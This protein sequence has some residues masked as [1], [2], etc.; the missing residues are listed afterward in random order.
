M[1][2]QQVLGEALVRATSNRTLGAWDKPKVGLAV[3]TNQTGEADIFVAQRL[4]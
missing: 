4:C 3:I 2:V 1:D